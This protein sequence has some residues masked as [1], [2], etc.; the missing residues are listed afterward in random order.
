MSRFLSR[1]FVVIIVALAIEGLV[2]TFKANHE[3]MTHLTH[4]AMLIIAVGVLL[5]AWGIF[6]RL[7]RYAEELEPEAMA[8]AKRE[9][10]KL[11]G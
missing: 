7:N 3:D 4:A 9:D 6:I 2:A 5:S 10:K 1:F 8:D 11:D